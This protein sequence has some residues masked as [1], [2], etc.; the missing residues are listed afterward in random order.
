MHDGF[1]SYRGSL[2]SGKPKFETTLHG[3]CGDLDTHAHTS[4]MSFAMVESVHEPQV[5]VRTDQCGGCVCVKCDIT[6]NGFLIEM[7]P[8]T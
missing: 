3:K 2:C 6:G 7:I 1:C 5:R 8:G 4:T